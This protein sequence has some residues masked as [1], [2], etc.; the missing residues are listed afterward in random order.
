M[1]LKILLCILISGL[2]AQA[3][4][5]APVPV[6]QT[7]QVFVE[8]LGVTGKIYTNCTVRT[9]NPAQV[10]ISFDGGGAMASI[11]D[12]PSN[13]QSQ[14]NYDPIAA[15]NYIEKQRQK[16][17]AQDKYYAQQAALAPPPGYTELASI[18]NQ[19]AQIKIKMTAEGKN[20]QIAAE[21]HQLKLS[22]GQSDKGE[23]LEFLQVDQNY[24]RNRGIYQ[25]QIAALELQAFEIRQLYN[26]TEPKTE[27]RKR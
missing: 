16:K 15:K 4:T 11:A 3:Q 23:A 10:I 27:Q 26:I 9:L 19:I 17:L 25:K 5:N 7:N 12:L 24:F 14:F 2:T 6:T 22:A 20:Y 8:K 18:S 1:K 13:L 21:R